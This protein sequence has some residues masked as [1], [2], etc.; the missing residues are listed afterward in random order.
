MAVIEVN[1]LQK[2]FR[3]K[4]KEPGL[5]GSVQA[6][7]RPTYSEVAAVKD[8]SF[9]VQTGELLAFIGPNGA[10]KST[11]IKMLTGILNPTAGTARVLGLV[12][13]EARR[14]LAFSIGSVFGQKSQ[15]WY[16]LPALDSF[17]LLGSI[18]EIDDRAFSKRLGQVVELFELEGFIKTPVRK[19]SLGQR[20]RCEI[21]ASILHRPKVIFLDEPTIGLDVVAKLKIREL[22]KRLNEEEKT[23]IFLTSHDAGDIEQ[24]CKRVIVINHGEIILDTST[25]YLRHNYLTTKIVNVK[26]ATPCTELTLSNVEILKHT[27]KGVK[28]RVNTKFNSIE[29]VL[30]QLFAQV[31]TADISV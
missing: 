28:L 1:G 8:I 5:R 12:P 7:L 13:W 10:G 2:V 11:T 14:Q 24:L 6:L 27:E 30:S 18:Y 29:N 20:M 15:L 17:R 3:T 26:F 31:D 21:A 4:M 9:E 22:I 16:H 23:T 19:L 25:S